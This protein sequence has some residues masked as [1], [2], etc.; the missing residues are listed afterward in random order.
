MRSRSES[1]RSGPAAF[2]ISESISAAMVSMASRSRA[3]RRASR[4]WLAKRGS[5]RTN[6]RSQMSNRNM[7]VVA[8]ERLPSKLSAEVATWIGSAAGTGVGAGAGGGA[9]G[10]AT[11]R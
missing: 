4:I 6:M 10:R 1:A 9:T 5:R 3:S 8:S 11:C 7:R 2:S